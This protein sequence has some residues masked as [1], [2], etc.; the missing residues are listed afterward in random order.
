RG[1]PRDRGVAADRTRDV[2]PAAD[3]YRHARD[4][5]H[6]T[7]AEGAGNGAGDAGDVHHR[8]RRGHAEGR[9]RDAACARPVEAVPP[10]RLG[11]GGRPAVQRGQCR[12]DL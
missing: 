10:A 9:Q 1:G 12:T 8:L 11:A 6:R 4:G 5:R 7:G 2:R 3:R